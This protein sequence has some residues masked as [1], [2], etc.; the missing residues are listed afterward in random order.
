M[1]VHRF[2]VQCLNDADELCV[3]HRWHGVSERKKELLAM[4]FPAMKA[5]GGHILCSLRHI[6]DGDVVRKSKVVNLV[7]QG[8]IIRLHGSCFG[9]LRVAGVFGRLLLRDH[10]VTELGLKVR[11]GGYGRCTATKRWGW[12]F[13]GNH[14]VLRQEQRHQW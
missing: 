7:E 2:R 3:R 5:G 11:R 14:R 6:A 8:S 12:G 4:P 13:Y 10:Q 1:G 9:I